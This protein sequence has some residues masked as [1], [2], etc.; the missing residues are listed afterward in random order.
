MSDRPILSRQISIAS[1]PMDGVVREVVANAAERK[2]L[3]EANGLVA[4]RSLAAE[5]LLTALPEGVVSVE[6]R[7]KADLVQNCVITLVPV[8]QL[9]DEPVA[10]R[11]APAGS[12]A[13]PPPPKPGAEVM[14]DLQFAEPPEQ[15][16]G[17][18][19]DLG[20]IAEEH[21][22]LAID[23]YPRAPGAAL[24]E[25]LPEEPGTPDSPFAAL[26]ALRNKASG[27]G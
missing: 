9:I 15:L 27:A 6:G 13:A 23:P 8:D 10:V 26:A 25:P 16:F 2:A 21:F 7:V 5:F 18:T 19:L 3:A 24:P 20:A 17:P 4:L 12:R 14:V 11:F 22:V 1:I